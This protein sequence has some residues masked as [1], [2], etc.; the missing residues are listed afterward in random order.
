ME[1]KG[2]QGIR[3]VV[4]EMEIVTFSNIKWR[5]WKWIYWIN[6]ICS[7]ANCKYIKAQNE[8][9]QGVDDTYK[10]KVEDNADQCA[11]ADSGGNDYNGTEYP[12][13]SRALHTH[14]HSKPQNGIK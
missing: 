7:K 1:E 10:K 14:A 2:K 4:M 8:L 5:K 6:T 12:P 11:F 9:W 3:A 13:G